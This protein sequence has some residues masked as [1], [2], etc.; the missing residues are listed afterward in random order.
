MLF[1]I[2]IHVFPAQGL[3][4]SRTG[5]LSNPIPTSHLCHITIAFVSDLFV[6]QL[7]NYMNSEVFGLIT[8]M[9]STEFKRTNSNTKTSAA[10][11]S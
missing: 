11:S 4:Q 2:S 9:G 3:V 5:L 8:L 1:T 7:A 6:A 10:F